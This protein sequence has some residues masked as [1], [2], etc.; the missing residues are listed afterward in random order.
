MKKYMVPLMVGLL[1]AIG[2]AAGTN[3]L[4]PLIQP[5]TTDN[6]SISSNN[7]NT[8]QNDTAN[9]TSNNNSSI[10]QSN[11]STSSQNMSETINDSQKVQNYDSNSKTQDTVF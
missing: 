6:N 11:S 7:F 2:G 9:T 8:F 3:V 4:T 5:N 10:D 1:L